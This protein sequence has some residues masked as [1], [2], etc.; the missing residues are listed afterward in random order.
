MILR[1]EPRPWAGSFAQ[2]AAQRA[3]QKEPRVSLRGSIRKALA[4]LKKDFLVESS[5]KL[6]F[7]FNIFSVLT[8][9]LVYYFIDKL[10]GQRLV[11]HLEAYGVN[12]FSY[13]LLGMA[14]F[15]YAGTGLGSF[16][17]RIRGEQMS[18]TLEAVLATPT[19]PSTLLF[20]L[21]LW[22]FCIAT[23]DLIIY[24]VLGAFFFHIDFSN[25]NIP[26]ALL[27]FL[28]TATSFSGLGILSASFILVLKRG[29]PVS[30][31]ISSLE[32]L[33]G[34]VYFP[35][36]V[37][38]A[39][40]QVVAKCLPITYTV[41]AIQLAVYQGYGIRQLRTEIG[42]LFAFSI[43]LI[44]LSLFVFRH[45]LRRARANGSLAQY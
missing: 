17:N 43:I 24:L 12:Y 26:A 32:G 4:F 39:W 34:G 35:I 40:L 22:N 20:S 36:A 6:A 38:P 18:G 25:V 23:F 13:V 28:L 33:V 5:Y 41:R 19:R 9:V 31:V 45:A 10:F 29:N 14:F 30:W 27:I 11:P 8:S 3:T 7:L 37:L 16:A 44:P 15:S 42:F 2:G 21:G 1:R